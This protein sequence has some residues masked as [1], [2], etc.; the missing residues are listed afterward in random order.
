MKKS[1]FNAF[2][3][4]MIPQHPMLTIALTALTPYLSSPMMRANKCQ[5]I[6]GHLSPPCFK[7]ST[8]PATQPGIQQVSSFSLFS[9]TAK[10]LC[11]IEYC[12]INITESSPFSSTQTDQRKRYYFTE[13]IQY[14]EDEKFN[15]CLIDL[16][17][18][19]IMK[20][21][22]LTTNQFPAVNS[23]ITA[24]LPN[25]GEFQLW[26]VLNSLSLDFLNSYLY[27]NLIFPFG[28]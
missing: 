8:L 14:Q 15:F 25:S 17:C 20:F 10:I 19:C 27:L 16:V 2:Q 6:C 9:H 24:K 3:W 23:I 1:F 7:E 22:L 13:I 5:G 26:R 12:I 28:W 18:C 4:S 11:I 21:D